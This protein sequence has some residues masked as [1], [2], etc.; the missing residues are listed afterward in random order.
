MQVEMEADNWQRCYARSRHMAKRNVIIG[1]RDIEVLMALDCCPLTPSQLRK[2]SDSFDQPFSDDHILRRRLRLI[3]EA[4]FIRSW[5]YAVASDGRSPR[6]YRLTREGFRLLHGMNAVLPS[7]RQF[8]GLATGHH[9]HTLS[10]ADFLVQTIVDAHRHNAIIQHVAPENSFRLEAGGFVLYPDLGFQVATP[11]GRSFHFVVELDNGT[12][13]VRTRRDV[14]SIERKLRG[15][16]AHQSQF[17]ADDPDRY[18]VLFITTR[19]TQR[20]QHMLDLAGNVMTNPQRTVF[21]GCDLASWLAGDPFKDALLVDH[22][23]LKR[24]LVPRETLLKTQKHQHEATQ[25]SIPK[26][27]V[28]LLARTT[29]RC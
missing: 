25:A 20:L 6:Y 22:R 5:P 1:D 29:A 26:T 21:V 16:D 7:R 23:G 12:E 15:Y 14:E 28:G 24:T 11:D 2:L 4:G 8:E 18:L 27:D 17:S 13:R 19:G 10:L 3:S 9:H